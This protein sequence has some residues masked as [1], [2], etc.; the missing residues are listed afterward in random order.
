MKK[1]NL[2]AFENAKL[3]K[4]TDLN[5]ILGGRAGSSGSTGD[6]KISYKATWEGSYGGSS[7]KDV[8]FDDGHESCTVLD[9]ALED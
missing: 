5:Q 6:A 4:V 2:S 8:I 9:S 3:G 1:S 7:A